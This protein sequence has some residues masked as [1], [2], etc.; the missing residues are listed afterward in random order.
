M[1]MMSWPST[2]I[3]VDEPIRTVELAYRLRTETTLANSQSTPVDL[4][5]SGVGFEPTSATGRLLWGTN[6]EQ[7]DG[8]NR[9]QSES[10][11]GVW[12]RQNQMC[13]PRRR[14]VDRS[15]LRDGESAA[16]RARSTSE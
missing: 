15:P 14:C 10:R 12:A 6:G 7:A 1:L 2:P 4:D 16:S 3:R 11:P 5:A 9:T 13:E 8:A